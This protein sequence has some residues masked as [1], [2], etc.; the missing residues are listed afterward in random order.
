MKI[1]NIKNWSTEKIASRVLYLLIGLSVLVFAAFYLIGF[2]RPYEEDPNFNAPML[3][4]L[5]L[6]FMYLLVLVTMAIAAW[7][8]VRSLRYH[9]K[10]ES[11]ENGVPTAKISYATVIITAISLVLTFIFGSSS[12]MS[13]NGHPYSDA[14]WLKTA[15]MFVNTS[16]ILM[17]LAVAAVIYGATKYYRRNNK[18]DV[19]A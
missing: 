19:H 6:V 4:D 11:M 10:E 16:I 1:G 7:A 15:D 13:I 9:R 18:N 14:F 2:N 17:L 3:T 12:T 5:L 8:V